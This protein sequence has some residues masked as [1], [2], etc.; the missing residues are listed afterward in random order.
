MASDPFDTL[1]FEARFDLD[2]ADIQRAYLLRAAACHPDLVG[3]DPERV[4]EADRRSAALN[5]AKATL[6]DPE[7]RARALLERLGGGGGGGLGDGRE[8]PDG[9]LMEIMETRMAVEEAA[10]SGDAAEM[11]R[12]RDWVAAERERYIER[13]GG[14]FAAVQE[15]QEVQEV[16]DVG[17]MGE[18]VEMGDVVEVGDVGVKEGVGGASVPPENL[19]EIQRQLNAWRYIERMLEQIGA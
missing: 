8:L 11:A 16:G 3:A 12:W 10:D 6:L 9:F 18:V 2:P 19:A 13:L 1:G 5:T 4:A 17:E 7:T 14:L 15:V